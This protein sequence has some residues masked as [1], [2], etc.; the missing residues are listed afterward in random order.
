MAPA[1]WT[2]SPPRFGWGSWTSGGRIRDKAEGVVRLD[3]K[4][5][6]ALAADVHILQADVRAVQLAKAAIRTGVDLLL[7]LAGFAERTSTAS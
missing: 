5:A 7:E 3:G 4:P 6:I 2:R 1:S